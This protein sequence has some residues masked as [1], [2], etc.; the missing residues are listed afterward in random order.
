MKKITLLSISFLLLSFATM[1]QQTWEWSDYG[2]SID[3]PDDF[4]VSKNTHEEFDAEGDGMELMMYVFEE[5]ITLEELD[6][7]TI[8]AAEEMELEEVDAV[9]DI[10]IDGLEGQYIAGYKNGNA[11]LLVGLLDPDSETNFF[12]IITFH[13]EDDIAEDDAMGILESIRRI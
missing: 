5:D 12:V 7:A 9:Q 3:L 10:T 4:E 8:I 1:A 2:I 13:D 6:E 11:V